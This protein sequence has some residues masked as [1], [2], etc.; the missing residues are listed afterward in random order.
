MKPT[1]F[2]IIGVLT[3]HIQIVH[4]YRGFG[5]LPQKSVHE[6]ECLNAAIHAEVDSR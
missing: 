1:K 6:I 3:D 2:E 4:N 5:R